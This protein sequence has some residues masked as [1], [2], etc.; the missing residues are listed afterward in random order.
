MIKKNIYI[1]GGGFLGLATAKSLL[2]KTSKIHVIERSNS[3]GG[4]AMPLNYNGYWIDKYY[5]FYFLHDDLYVKKFFSDCKINYDVVWKKI[6]TETYINNKFYNFDNL[7]SII[8]I[9]KFETFKVIISLV[10]IKLANP[11]NNLDHITANKWAK[12]EFGT[13]LYKLVWMPLLKSKFGEHWK[14]ISA[15]WLAKRIK[16]HLTTKTFNG[17][18]MFGYLIPTYKIII[19][20]I[21]NLILKHNGKIYL[22]QKIHSIKI[23]NNVITQMH[24]GRKKIQ[25]EKNSIVIST[26][27]YANLKL[28]NNLE[29]KISNIQKFNTI[30][31]V[32]LIL[33]LKKKLSN[34]YWTTVPDKKIIFDVIIQ[35]NRLYAHGDFEVVYLSKYYSL[36]DRFAKFE[37]KFIQQL[38]I[39]DIQTMFKKIKKDDIIS[40]K[41]FR[42]NY[43]APVPIVKS[44]SEIENVKTSIKNFYHTSYDCCYPNDRGVGNSINLGYKMSEIINKE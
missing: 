10:K 28:I 29:K 31:A 2:S 32:L 20:K 25:L 24:I 13:N 35:Q 15:L 22:N 1:I 4:L 14:K 9:C 19:N 16:T 40:A 37:N 38:F 44:F 3:L 39:K 8:K 11:K 17:K 12:K 23:K 43:A 41:L 27:P 7:F 34:C 6:K 33:F 18:S 21:K 5:H 36:N 30:G 26:I 42:T